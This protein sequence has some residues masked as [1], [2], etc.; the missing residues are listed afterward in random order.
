MRF[1]SQL[2]F[3][4]TAAAIIVTAVS[5][6]GILPVAADESWQPFNPFAELERKKAAK[7]AAAAPAPTDTRPFLSPIQGNDATRAAAS[8]VPTMAE[9]DRPPPTTAPST[10]DTVMRD[11]IPPP[12]EKGD[13]APVMATDGSGLPSELW[14]GLTVETIEKLISQIE[15][16][17]R[18][19]ALHGLW[20]R[21]ITASIM[22]PSGGGSDSAFTALRLE[23]L[24]R[25][26]LAKEA[27]G[28]LAKQAATTE[29]LL[30]MLSA[31]N[32][33]AS[34]N[35]AR[36][37][38]IV[39]QATASKS[40]MPPRLKGQAILMSGYCAAVANDAASA[41][42]AAELAREQGEAQSVGIQALDAISIGSKPKIT[43][44]K[45]LSLLDYR[46]VERVG[47]LPHKDILEKGEP[48]LLVAL[49]SDAAT[50][51]DLGLPAAEAAT[52]LNALAPEMLAAIYRANAST[53]APDALLAGGQ[54]QGASR[55][56]A[57][58]KAAEAEQNPMKKSRLIRA[59]IDD[60]KRSGLQFQAL[61]MAAETAAKLNPQP[62]ISWFAETGIEIGLASGRYDL[63]RS[64]IATAN[65][66]ARA[67]GNLDHW[68][69]LAD[70]ADP[71]LKDRG[72]NLS[73]LE[74]LAQTG[75][76]K[77]D[78]LHRLATV[79]DALSYNVP[80]PLWDAA[81]R[82]PQP[83][84]GYLPETGVLSELQD[85]AKK[86]EFG[87]TVLL[88]MKTL[89]PN[90][91]EG[92]H[93]IALGDSIRALKQAGLEPDARRLGLEALLGAWPRSTAN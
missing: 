90:G 88:A 5:A 72:K 57:L 93:M 14:R 25:S 2:S 3:S 83:T 60:A 32:E 41:G 47:G 21:F 20:K 76:F 10:R 58:Y 53:D 61:Q 37:C 18:S 7:R 62:E 31:R 11:A 49:S 64:W 71:N 87:R 55:R 86:K 75:R 42:L 40:A 8:A 81:S 43:L 23:A 16:P 45:H 9:R 17:P 15:I 39:Q 70:I 4:Q 38:E 73:A 54:L 46:L 44:P 67:G 36:A 63:A 27:A 19:P 78:D 65:E 28:E 84:S 85:A 30:T 33:L 48:A 6:G 34:G 51:V 91:A 52:R 59:F 1:K 74:L 80:I 35:A 68:L 79:L 26:G 92:A 69:A 12:V 56:A 89:G 77:P 24:Y 82:T 22:V 66:Q 29:P 13:L 50:P